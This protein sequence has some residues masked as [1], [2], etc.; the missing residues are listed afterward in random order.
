MSFGRLESLRRNIGVRLGL[1]YAFVFALSSIALLS[2]AYY[3]LAAA[4]GRKDR[5]VLESRLKEVGTVFQAGGVTAVRRWTQNQ[6]AQVQHALYVR[7]I[8]PFRGVDYVSFPDDWLTL[9][10]VPND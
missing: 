6:P 10:D 9:R 2:L 5:E 8:N 3:L 7:L 4:I 1:W